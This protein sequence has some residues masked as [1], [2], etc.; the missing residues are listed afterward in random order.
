MGGTT[1]HLGEATGVVRDEGPRSTRSRAST[2]SVVCAAMLAFLGCSDDSGTT[3]LEQTAEIS[4]PLTSPSLNYP[5]A[6]T[7]NHETSVAYVSGAGAPPGGSAA[8]GRWVAVANNFE[9]GANIQWSWMYSTDG[10]GT[11]WTFRKQTTPTEFGVPP[12]ISPSGGTFVGWAGD[13]SI[14]AVTPGCAGDW[15]NGGK[16][17]VGVNLARTTTDPTNASD[18]IVA[19]SEDGGET[20]GNLQWVTTSPEN[21][22]RVD[23]PF[24][25][26]SPSPPCDTYVS[27]Y[28]NYGG[29]HTGYLRKIHYDLPPA[30]SFQNTTAIQIK[31]ESPVEELNRINFGFG[32]LPP[33]C[34]SGQQGIYV[35]YSNQGTQRCPH[36]GQQID[37]LETN[38]TLRV[39]D[40]GNQQ[41]YGPFGVGSVS[42][43]SS[44]VGSPLSVAYSNSQD[45]HIAV[46]P[47]TGRSWI[48]HTTQAGAGSPVR[49]EVRQVVLV[50]NGGSGGGG[51]SGVEAV[52]RLWDS[53]QLAPTNGASDQWLPAIAMH[54]ST[55]LVPRVA[56]YWYGTVDSANSQAAL[57]AAYQEGIGAFN[58]PYQITTPFFPVGGASTWTVNANPDVWDYQTLGSSRQNQSFL[59][60]WAGDRRTSVVPGWNGGFETGQFTAYSTPNTPSTDW[61]PSGAATSVTN[62][63]LHSGI[64]S[65]RLGLV[66][67]TFGD[68]TISQQFTAPNG[69]S[70]VSF[71]YNMHCPEPNAHY[72]WF[73]AKLQD[74]T[75]LPAQPPVTILPAGPD[76]GAQCSNALGWQRSPQVAVVPGNKYT[77]TITSHDDGWPTDPSY[78][79]VDDLIFETTS[80]TYMMSALSQ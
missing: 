34:T 47:S 10:S 27:W 61:V 77:I 70:T 37:N 39:Y 5:I 13:V 4:S 59:S 6:R 19:L 11:S 35:V 80:P 48:T 12:G 9:G 78:T 75:T 44:C 40:T 31:K 66:T 7:F 45:P 1:E 15:S 33:S 79:D 24:V 46:D 51:G 53:A 50:C 73:T 49:V 67:P 26:S 43:F 42:H 52:T 65:A 29:Q 72:A 8:P 25:F 32:A 14:A 64:Y 68:S 76:N 22:T 20:W 60:V 28:S 74:D 62:L 63:D 17:L 71:W 54:Q 21:G 2:R 38:W 56:V 58:G 3:A 69:A 18:I 23:Q 30:P 36:N 16:R 41:W 55:T 57:F